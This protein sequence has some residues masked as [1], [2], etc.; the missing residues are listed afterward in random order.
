MFLLYVKVNSGILKTFLL[1]KICK[2]N[3]L[4]I[5]SITYGPGD[6]KLEHTDNDFIELEEYYKSIE[7][8]SKFYSKF[9]EIYHKSNP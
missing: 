7:I 3:N 4:Y 2:I 8:Y 6:P 9:F 5:P 1:D